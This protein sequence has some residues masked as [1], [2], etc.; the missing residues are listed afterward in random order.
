[1]KRE[2]TDKHTSV[3]S[4]FR[5]KNNQPLCMLWIIINTSLERRRE[6]IYSQ[7]FPNSNHFLRKSSTNCRT[8]WKGIEIIWITDIAK[9]KIKIL[10]IFMLRYWKCNSVLRDSTRIIGF[11]P[12]FS[13]VLNCQWPKKTS[14]LL[15]FTSTW[16]AIL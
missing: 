4:W 7:T 15:K 10:D 5:W 13:I 6:L 1:M 9:I 12:R 2:R 11:I 16:S 14:F 3:K 8:K